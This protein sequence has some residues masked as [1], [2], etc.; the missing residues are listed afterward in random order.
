MGNGGIV[1]RPRFFQPHDD[2]LSSPRVRLVAV[3]EA[4]TH[5]PFVASPFGRNGRDRCERVCIPFGACR[6]RTLDELG[7]S[8]LSEFI[9]RTYDRKAVQGVDVR[10]CGCLHTSG[11]HFRIITGSRSGSVRDRIVDRGCRPSP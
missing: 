7:R 9:D 3:E 10:W 2:D 11:L 6:R 8:C 4:C 1:S 5:H